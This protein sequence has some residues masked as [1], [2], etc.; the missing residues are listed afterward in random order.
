M[1]PSEILTT[2]PYTVSCSF[3]VDLQAVEQNRRKRRQIRS[4]IG[5][6]RKIVSIIGI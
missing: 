6:G 2:L 3:V 1:S 5:F 4:V